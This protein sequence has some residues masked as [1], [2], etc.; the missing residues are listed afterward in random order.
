MSGRH[1]MDKNPDTLA[2]SE[3]AW[4]GED[5]DG[6]IEDVVKRDMKYV[7]LCSGSVDFPDCL[8]VSGT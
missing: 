8:V 1:S 7:C 6:G 5:W 3:E 4:S 2:Q